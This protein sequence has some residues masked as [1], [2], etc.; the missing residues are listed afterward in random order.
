QGIEYRSSEFPAGW[1]ERAYALLHH[2]LESTAGGTATDRRTGLV[3]FGQYLFRSLLPTELQRTLR[4]LVD[5][6][7]TLLILSDQDSALPWTLLHDGNA[8]LGEHFSI[9]RWLRELH[10]TR[11]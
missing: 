1:L 2:T 7:H 3:S 9:G 6:G 11:P 5:I 8:F 10:D 4:S